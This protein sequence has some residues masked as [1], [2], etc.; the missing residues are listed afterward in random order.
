MA[1]MLTMASRGL[2]RPVLRLLNNYLERN[3]SEVCTIFI[4][5][6]RKLNKMHLWSMGYIM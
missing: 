5:E 3:L 1:G 6:N 2:P 4:Y